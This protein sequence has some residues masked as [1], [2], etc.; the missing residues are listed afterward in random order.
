MTFNFLKFKTY[1]L[2]S[3]DFKLC[4]SS[5]K[6]IS[7]I[8]FNFIMRT[9]VKFHMKKSPSINFSRF[10]LKLFAYLHFY[11]FSQIKITFTSYF[12]RFYDVLLVLG[13]C[14]WY[15]AVC[16]TFKHNIVSCI[17]TIIMECSCFHVKFMILDRDRPDSLSCE[18]ST[19]PLGGI[20]TW[21]QIFCAIS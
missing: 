11:V 17:M 15:F 4:F 9:L 3:D 7:S 19:L 8:F 21:E 10:S 13:Q 1:I 16:C 2:I 5:L 18:I 14:S 20:L 12:S 6:N